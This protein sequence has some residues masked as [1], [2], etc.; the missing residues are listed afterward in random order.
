MQNEAVVYTVERETGN[1]LVKR[2]DWDDRFDLVGKTSL[3]SIQRQ[4]MIES[5]QISGDEDYL[6]KCLLNAFPRLA[7]H[8]LHSNSVH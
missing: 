8:F 6:H 4:N 1:P 3:V 7:M 5:G 2:G